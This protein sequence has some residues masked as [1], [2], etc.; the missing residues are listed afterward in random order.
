MTLEKKE[1]EKIKLKLA[2]KEE[3]TTR[4]VGCSLF[5]VFLYRWHF[6]NLTK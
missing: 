2:R 5:N 1:V 3:T 4:K 6:P